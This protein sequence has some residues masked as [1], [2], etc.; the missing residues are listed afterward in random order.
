MIIDVILGKNIDTCMW[1]NDLKKIKVD[2]IAVIDYESIVDFEEVD[3]VIFLSPS[4]AKKY[5]KKF[6]AINYYK[7]LY[8]YPGMNAD[9]SSLFRK[10]KE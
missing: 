4:C 9:M 2:Q 10:E 8:A 3:G 6:D 5:L 7:S 1:I